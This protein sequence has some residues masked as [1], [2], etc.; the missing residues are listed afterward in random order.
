MLIGRRVKEARLEKK[1]SQEELGKMLGV[2]K[3]SICGYENGTRTPTMQNFLDLNLNQTISFHIKSIEQSEAV[4]LIKQ[5]ITDIDRMTI[6]EQKKA[7]RSGYD[8]DIIPSDLNTFGIDAKRLLSDLQSRN[9]RL[10]DVLILFKTEGSTQQELKDAY[11]QIAGIA[12]KHNCEIKPLSFI[13]E[14]GFSST[15]MLG[16]SHLSMK[17]KLTTKATAIFLPFTTEEIFMAGGGQYYGLNAVSN[18]VILANRKKL[19]NPNGIVVGR[20]G[21]GK[22]FS[23]KREICD[24]FITTDDDIVICDPES[25]YQPLVE[26]LGGTV[27][28]ISANSKD[29]VNPLDIN[30]NYAEEDN[31]LAMKSDFVLSLFELILARKTGM[32]AIERSVIDR[33]L[34]LIYAPYF[35]SG[36]KEDLPILGD[37]HEALLKQPEPEAKTLA[38]ALEL[39]VEGSLSVFN[40]KTNVD[41][42]NRVVC[43]DTKELGNSLKKIGMLIV[44]DQVWNRVTANRSAHKSTRYYMDE[45][46]L[47]L[48]EEQTANY[49]V[50]I[51]KRFRKWGG[52]PTG[53]TQNI[54]D[55]FA[56]REIENILENSDFIY[57]L[58]Q[59]KGDREILAK[60]L[61]IS[62]KQEEFITNSK[63]GEGLLFF[64]DT[65]IP[66]KDHFDH[67][68][69]LYS[70]MT[71]KPEEV[72]LRDKKRGN[73]L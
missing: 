50:E 3:V 69:K 17:R 2:T 67:S 44:Q 52:I 5:K 53:I 56:S 58:G 23:V 42:Q 41:T 1:M 10:F 49:S 11:L 8:M 66:F 19:V 62:K 16:E 57:M 63:E 4:K 64:G 28:R 9:E 26:A 47:L 34:P 29:Y 38:T 25:E 48:K 72:K 59:A 65:I 27:I 6:E 31:P 51:W 40:H 33:C 20:P 13:Q 68:L 37:L 46:H 7:V 15:L 21:T 24:V 36:K 70:L 18:N 61:H 30:E 60:Y 55:L 35:K 45:F 32:E 54:K 43:F 39:Y 12:Q 22:S 14:E 73:K 71:T